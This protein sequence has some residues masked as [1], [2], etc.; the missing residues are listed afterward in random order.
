M[1][2]RD[3]LPALIASAATPGASGD[4]LTRLVGGCWPPASDATVPAARAWVRRWSPR[5]MDL[6]AASAGLCWN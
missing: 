3:D 2:D 4:V 1:P 5:S 6:A